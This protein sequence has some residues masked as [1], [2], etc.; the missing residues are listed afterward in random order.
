MIGG[1]L[2]AQSIPCLVLTHGRDDICEKSLASFIEGD[3]RFA[4]DI[5][6]NPGA[7]ENGSFLQAARNWVTAGR[8]RSLT[9]FDVNISNNAIL[10]YLLANRDRYERDYVLLTDG[11]IVAPPGLV[12]EQVRIFQS[13]SHIFACGLRL[14]ASRWDD[15][16]PPKKES[17][18]RFNSDRF[19]TEDYVDSATGLWATM[20]RIVCGAFPKISA[21]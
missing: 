20:F 16:L 15:S 5:V 19:E 4:I 18:L 7:E 12:D 8:T 13:H 21:T 3:T 11:D 2:R 6:H 17:L 10:L 14:D 9:V 1:E